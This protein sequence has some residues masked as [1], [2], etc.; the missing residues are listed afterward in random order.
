MGLGCPRKK[1]GSEDDQIIQKL[2][3]NRRKTLANLCNNF[4]VSRFNI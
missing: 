3:T 2:E 4:A 1:N